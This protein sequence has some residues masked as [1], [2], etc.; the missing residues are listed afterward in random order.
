MRKG[1]SLWGWAG[2]GGVPKRSPNAT[3]AAHADIHRNPPTPMDAAAHLRDTILDKLHTRAW[4]AG[5]RIPTA[6]ALSEE[7][8]LSRSTVRRVLR[9]SKRK[10]LITQTVGSGTYVAEQVQQALSDLA[11]PPAAASVSPAELMSAR[12]VLE[13]ALIEMVIGNA[14]PADFVRMDECNQ[15][16]EAA[17]TLEEFEKW[18]AALHE[19]IAEAAHN[20]FITGVFRLMNDVRSNSE[21]G[22]LKRRS[23]TPARR[24]EYQQEH[25]ALVAA[26]KNRDAERARALS[27]AH[28]VHVRTNMLGY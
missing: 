2:A 11:P 5:H 13:P 26:L 3:I 17:T 16:A 12:L 27:V 9:D 19:A 18:D 7:F 21:W 4:R 22:V 8:G 20:G 10:R 25:R 23:A 24:V 1:V 28:L 15:R 6:R 14:T